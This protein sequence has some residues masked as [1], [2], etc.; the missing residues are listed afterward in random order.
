MAQT[1]AAAIDMEVQ[2]VESLVSGGGSVAGADLGGG[3]PDLSF[4]HMFLNADWVVQSVMIILLLMSFRSWM[5]IAGK[6]WLFMT[7]DKRMTKF[8]RS[9][10]SGDAL[11]KRFDRL[12]N[13]A[14][15]PLSRAF[16]AGMHEWQSQKKYM[17]SGSTGGE[18]MTV[19]VSG[20]TRSTPDPQRQ[21]EVRERVFEMMDVVRGREV[22]QMEKGLGFLATVGSAAP[23]IGLFGTVWGIMSSFQSIAVMK[24]TSLSVVA[25]GIAE[26][27]FATAIGLFAAIPAVIAFNHYQGRLA[28][29]SNRIDEFTDEFGIAVMQDGR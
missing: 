1:G 26:A 29:L 22:T 11:E 12:K 15:H 2:A 16:V 18:G 28:G 20:R 5:I 10:W 24:N 21:V 23:F 19:Q 6:W 27:L 8:E 4:S 14:D 7:M 13:N 25:P 3:G 17:S 9:I